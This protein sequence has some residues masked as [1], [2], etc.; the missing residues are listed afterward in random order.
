MP[1]DSAFA[2]FSVVQR[3]DSPEA[4]SVDSSWL[5]RG[6]KKCSRLVKIWS[7][8]SIPAVASGVQTS[9]ANKID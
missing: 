2:K 6:S 7:G 3:Q 5:E 9:S 1:K 4:V 8:T